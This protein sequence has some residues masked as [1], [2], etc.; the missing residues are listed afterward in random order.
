MRVLTSVRTNSVCIIALASALLGADQAAAQ[1]PCQDQIAAI[2]SNCSSDYLS[3]CSSVPLGGSQALQ[4][5]KSN[6][7]KLSSGL[8]ACGEG[9]SRDR[10]SAFECGHTGT[11]EACGR[12]EIGSAGT[13]SLSDHTAG[14]ICARI[15]GDH[16][17]GYT[18]AVDYRILSAGKPRSGR[19]GKVRVARQICQE[20]RLNYRQGCSALRR[21]SCARLHPAAQEI[22]AR[23]VLPRR[24]SCLLPWRG[25]RVP[26]EPSPA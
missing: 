9:G 6:L 2:K 18:R 4:C 7:A 23:T 5:L 12:S 11:L 1:Q 14:S 17:T 19:N 21:R 15:L 24:L 25:C 16:A 22:D 3:Y 8:P 13:P 10:R 26:V 20:N